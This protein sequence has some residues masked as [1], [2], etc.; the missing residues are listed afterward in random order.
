MNVGN[1]GSEFRVAY[2]VLGDAVNLGSRFE[3]LTKQYG[4]SIIVGE[5]TRKIISEFEFIELDQVRVKGK[6]KPTRI[7][8]PL[9]YKIELPAAV[10]KEVRHFK[11]ALEMYRRQSWDAAEREIF[12]L[13]QANR[14][15]KLYQIYL[16]R[17]M[18][19]RQ[20]PPGEAWDGVWTH[21]SKK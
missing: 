14:Q 19:Y 11:Q 21:T 1:M 13:S 12:S 9:G 6:E 3:G 18:H 2:T 5:E 10:R 20:N 4:V 7:Y 15:C 17:I 8:Q 16:E